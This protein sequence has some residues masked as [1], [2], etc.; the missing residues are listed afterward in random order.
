MVPSVAMKGATR[1]LVMTAPFIQPMTQP[2]KMTMRMT[3]GTL[4]YSV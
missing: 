3:M 1:S 2:S 4:K